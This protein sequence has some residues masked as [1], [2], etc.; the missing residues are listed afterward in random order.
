MA[1]FRWKVGKNNQWW[2]SAILNFTKFRKLKTEFCRTFRISLFYSGWLARISHL[3]PCYE[4]F[5]HNM[6]KHTFLEKK[7]PSILNLSTTFLAVSIFPPFLRCL[8]FHEK[9]KSLISMHLFRAYH[10]V[11]KTRE[12]GTFFEIEPFDASN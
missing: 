8:V 2:L 7:Y 11:N 10:F 12:K 3:F 4:M 9:W 5:C 6:R 1:Y